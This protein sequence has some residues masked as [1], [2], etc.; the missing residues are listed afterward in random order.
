MSYNESIKEQEQSKKIQEMFN[1]IADKYDF[2]NGL[3]SF[4][5]DDNWRRN[6]I[7]LANIKSGNKVLDLACGTGD[8][9]TEI[10]KQHPDAV[11][12]GADF[13]V[14]M[15]HIS[16]KKLGSIPFTAADAHN[17]PFKDNSFDRLTIAFGFRNI[18]DK[19]R[20]LSELYRVIKPGGKVCILELTRPENKVT[21]F[22]Y[23]IYFM[24]LLPFIGGLFSSKKAY[25][26]LPDSVYHFP[27]RKEYRSMIEEAGFKN[28]HFKSLVFGAVT[29]AIMDKEI[30]PDN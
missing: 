13:S 28:I 25:K 19:A 14:N 12:Y 3:L 15:L 30:K 23:R 22:F 5:L 21:S 4:A 11:I 10:K 2:L 16:Q 9:I 17:L 27:K 24:H 8:M 6:A 20:G 7:R 1:S 26:Y 29:I 18:T